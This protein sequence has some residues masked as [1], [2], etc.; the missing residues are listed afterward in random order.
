MLQGSVSKAQPINL[1]ISLAS[2]V[3]SISTC[4]D[5]ESTAFWLFCPWEIRLMTFVGIL[6]HY[7][8]NFAFLVGKI[9]SKTAL[10][11]PQT[12]RNL[13]KIGFGDAVGT[14]VYVYLPFPKHLSAHF[15]WK[16][17]KME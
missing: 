1:L 11:S 4:L 9:S 6:D 14:L 13:L 2:T 5:C 8:G 10:K 17:H 12:P 15:K 16:G 3:V 7:L